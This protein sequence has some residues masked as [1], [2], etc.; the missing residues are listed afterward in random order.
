MHGFTQLHALQHRSIEYF[1]GAGGL[2]VLL[3]EN[4]GTFLIHLSLPRFFF[5]VGSW[6][7]LPHGWQHSHHSGSLCSSEP[8]CDVNIILQHRYQICH[9]AVSTFVSRLVKASSGEG[10]RK[11]DGVSECYPRDP[12][13]ALHSSVK[14]LLFIFRQKIFKVPNGLMP[15]TSLFSHWPL[16]LFFWL[17][18]RLELPA[19]QNVW[20]AQCCSVTEIMSCDW[21]LCCFDESNCIQLLFFLKED[22]NRTNNV[23]HTNAHSDC[24]LG[25][26][27]RTNFKLMVINTFYIATGG[28]YY[29]S[30]NTMYV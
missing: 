25:L 9:T 1:I 3:K 11:R 10:K 15:H 14:E 26:L 19:L 18:H 28:S 21:L 22:R 8:G 5:T 6:S 24:R 30:S 23:S 4:F 20:L 27:E 12:W 16:S 2:G 7:N 29:G 17:V 13:D